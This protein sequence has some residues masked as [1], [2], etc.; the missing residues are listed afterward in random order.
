MNWF[1]MWSLD[2]GGIIF[3]KILIFS[4][5]ILMTF[6]MFEIMKEDD[7]YIKN[8]LLLFGKKFRYERNN[9]YGKCIP[10]TLDFK[11]FTLKAR[12]LENIF[13]GFIWK[14]SCWRQIDHFLFLS[15][16]GQ[17]VT[18]PQLWVCSIIFFLIFG[19]WTKA[20]VYMKIKMG[21]FLYK[22]LSVENG[23]FYAK[24]LPKN[25]APS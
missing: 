21:F 16:T 9:Q 6:F 8:N 17:N 11:I 19:Q 2:K 20:K 10:I 25:I 3:Y 15:N 18:R 1:R 7:R 22:L 4:I 14:N 5:F 13:N 12:H 23:S 24:F